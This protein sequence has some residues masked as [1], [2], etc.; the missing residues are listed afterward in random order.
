MYVLYKGLAPVTKLDA[1][2]HVTSAGVLTMATPQQQEVL[3]KQQILKRFKFVVSIHSVPMFLLFSQRRV[4][5]GNPLVAVITVQLLLG[6]KC[7]CGLG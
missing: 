5:G 1:S 4:N 7:T 6:M 2:Q 3:C